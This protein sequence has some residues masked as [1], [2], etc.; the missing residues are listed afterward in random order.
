MTKFLLSETK[1]IS[2]LAHSQMTERP[3]LGFLGTNVMNPWELRHVA[4]ESF[5]WLYEYQG[6]EQFK[7]SLAAVLHEEKQYEASSLEASK[8]KYY[9]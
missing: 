4:C 7:N 1:P 2:G 5:L 6:Y 9:Q 3:K 8:D